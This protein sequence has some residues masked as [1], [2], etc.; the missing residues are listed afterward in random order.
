MNDLNEHLE[1]LSAAELIEFAKEQYV[2]NLKN[3]SPPK[4]SEQDTKKHDILMEN[5]KAHFASYEE[6]KKGHPGDIV[7]FQRGDFF[8]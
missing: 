4:I 3:D 7:L 2:I 1:K 5:T 6:V 8:S